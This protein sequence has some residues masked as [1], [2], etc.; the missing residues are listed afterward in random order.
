MAPCTVFIISETVQNI[1]TEVY[2][3]EDMVLRR[4]ARHCV[5][6]PHNTNSAIDSNSH[7]CFPFNFL[8]G[9]F[10]LNGL[11]LGCEASQSL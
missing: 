8:S 9:L 11:L 10:V 6:R 7:N 4:L 5:A 1:V 3:L 2:K